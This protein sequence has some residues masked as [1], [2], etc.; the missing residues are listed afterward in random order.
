MTKANVDNNNTDPTPN[1]SPEKGGENG[2]SWL[3]DA[4]MHFNL[5]QSTPMDA[6]NLI[7]SLQRRIRDEQ[8]QQQQQEESPRESATDYRKP[9]PRDA[10][11]NS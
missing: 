6:M 9:S 3:A 1:P 7:A 2:R 8:Q 4:V 11:P 5:S 10:M